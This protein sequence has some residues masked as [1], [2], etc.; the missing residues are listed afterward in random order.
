M[1]NRSCFFFAV[2]LLALSSCTQEPVVGNTQDQRTASVQVPEDCI[3]GVIRVKFKSEPTGTKAGGPDLSALANATMTRV[4]PPAGKWEARHRAWGLHLWYDI[5]FDADMPLSK[6]GETVAALDEFDV[7]EFIPRIKFDDVPSVLFDDP[8][9]PEQWGFYN[10]GSRDHSAAGCDIN[11]AR[12]WAIESGHPDVIVGIVDEGIDYNHEDLKQNMWINEAEKNGAAGVDDDNNGFVDDIYGFNFVT[13]DGKNP[14]GAVQPGS[15]G[16]HVA[17]TVAA[18]NNNGIGVSGT[19][20]GNGSPNTGVRVMSTQTGEE[21]SDASAFIGAAIVY[22]ADNGAV[23]I[24]CSWS[25]S[26]TETPA[27]I[28]EALQ[29]FS[30]NAGMDENG[31]QVGPMAGGVAIFSAGN[32]NSD[33][34]YPAAEDIVVAVASVGADYMRASYSN[35]GPWVDVCAPGGE[36]SLGN[37]ILSTVPGNGYDGFQGTSMAAPHVTGVAALL[38]S[39]YGVGRK[40]FTREKLIRLLKETANPKPYEVNDGFYRDQLGTGLVDA[41]AALIAEPISG[42]VPNPLTTFQAEAES[43]RI[44]LSWKVPDGDGASAYFFDVFYSTSSLASLDPAK[45]GEDVKVLRVPSSGQKA[46]SEMRALLS[47]LDFKTEYHIRIASESFG[48]E[49]AEPSEEKVVRTGQN[50]K[51]VI[52]AQNGTSLTLPSHGNGLLKFDINDPDNHTLRVSVSEIG[53]LYSSFAEGILSLSFNALEVEDGKTYQGTIT[54]SDGFDTVEQAFSITVKKNNAPTVSKPIE[55]L[56][57]TSITGSQTIDLSQ[58]FQDADEETLSYTVRLLS[59]YLVVR[60]TLSGAMLT[61]K[62][63]SYGISSMEVKAV[64][65]RGEEITQTFRLLVRDADRA[66]DLYPNP[67]QT[68][69]HIGV[70]EPKSASVTLIN[71]AGATVFSAESVSLDPFAPFKVDMSDQPAGTYYVLIGEDRYTIV[72]E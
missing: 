6:A 11:A 42:G 65:A 57:F 46:G 24:N 14:V 52:K 43:N 7:V 28:L 64:D 25:V 20:G 27:F 47:D 3:P 12:A 15:H 54:A 4:F 34:S 72:K 16:T 26:K 21:D 23:L 1:R 62:G 71:K 38:V 33:A 39:H 69:L 31:E 35:Y 48:G 45:P 10:D 68:D 37:P 53:G 66:Y 40:G 17:G 32:D 55:D 58:Y 2:F 18:V 8:R 60:S 5:H 70:G 36:A 9:L 50:A 56:I 44:Q 49:L 63:S 29:Y 61:L 67:V 19:A 30:A 13:H 51:P 22:A 59:D 41:Y